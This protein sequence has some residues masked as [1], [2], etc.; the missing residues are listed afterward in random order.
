MTDI[1][2]GGACLARGPTKET[3]RDG[4]FAKLQT[5]QDL[6]AI[7]KA[8]AAVQRAFGS[9]GVA[10][11]ASYKPE[12]PE[13]SLGR[14]HECAAAAGAVAVANW[15]LHGRPVARKRAPTATGSHGA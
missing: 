3:A 12:K 6:D 4:L 8:Q 5:R 1:G 10:V 11:D 7:G 14:T 13:E 15:F 9:P 2:H